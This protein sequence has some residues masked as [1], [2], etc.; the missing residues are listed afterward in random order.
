MVVEVRAAAA[1][2]EHNFQKNPLFLSY[3]LKYLT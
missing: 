3:N 2:K 1:E